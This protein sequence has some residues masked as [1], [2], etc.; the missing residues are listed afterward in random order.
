MEII[1]CLAVGVAIFVGIIGASV[2]FVYLVYA[3]AW[4]RWVVGL[5]VCVACSYVFGY[6]ACH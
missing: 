6:M 3:Y 2:G 5:G 4:A 1:K